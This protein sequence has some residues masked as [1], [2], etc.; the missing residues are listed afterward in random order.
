MAQ[1]QM[2]SLGRKRIQGPKM[3]LGYQQEGALVRDDAF[4]PASSSKGRCQGS[5]R[6][7]RDSLKT[8]QNLI[9]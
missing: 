8:D 2:K 3:T 5:Q 6:V 9:V 4:E 1:M 7:Q